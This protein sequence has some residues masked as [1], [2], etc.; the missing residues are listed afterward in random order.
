MKSIVVVLS[1]GFEELEA[2]SVIDILRRANVGVEVVGLRDVNVTGSRGVTI[3]CD[4]VF[5]YYSSLDFDGIVMVGGMDNAMS[6]SQDEKVLKL[7]QE[8]MYK[9]KMVAGICATP[10]LVFSEAGILDGKVATCYPSSSLIDILG[11]E[12]VDK[13]C[14]VCDNLITSQSPD[15][16]MEFALT[17]VKY[18]GYDAGA[19]YTELQGK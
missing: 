13:A 11:C 16:A 15:T 9:G 2:I 7:L 14:V 17:I 10:A 8:Y 1:A 3:V 19:I 6:L 12:Y 5:D 4:D 18:L